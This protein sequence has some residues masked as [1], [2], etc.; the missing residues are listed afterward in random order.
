[1]ADKKKTKLFAWVVAFILTL[2]TGDKIGAVALANKAIE[3]V[4][5]KAVDTLEVKTEVVTT[6]E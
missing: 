3:K 2:V 6:E 4:I 5:D 1:M